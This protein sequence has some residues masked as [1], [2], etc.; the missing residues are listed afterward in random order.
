MDCTPVLMVA[1]APLVYHERDIAVGEEFYA[2]PRHAPLLTI[3]KKA[4]KVGESVPAINKP[5]RAY[6][7]RDMRAE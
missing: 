3:I 4:S 7:R 5:K 2:D 6:R 1:T